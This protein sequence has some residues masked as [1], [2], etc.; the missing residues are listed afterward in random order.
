MRNILINH[1]FLPAVKMLACTEKIIVKR[2]VDNC[3]LSLIDKAAKCDT[4]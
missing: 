3:L 2:A 1:Y 4:K